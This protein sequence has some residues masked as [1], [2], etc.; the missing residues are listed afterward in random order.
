MYTL[1]GGERGGK[2]ERGTEREREG[3]G[4]SYSEDLTAKGTY[5]YVANYGLL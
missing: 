5:S 4:G 2:W 1:A 3:E